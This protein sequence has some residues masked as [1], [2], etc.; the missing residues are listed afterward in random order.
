MIEIW[1]D[2]DGHWID[3]DETLSNAIKAVITTEARLDCMM[4]T[5]S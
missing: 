2:V 4:A 5:I 3:T 1:E